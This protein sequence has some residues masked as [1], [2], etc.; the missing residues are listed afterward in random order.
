MITDVLTAANIPTEYDDG[1]G[2]IRQGM[3]FEWPAHILW[4]LRVPWP[5][6]GR[7]SSNAIERYVQA[8]PVSMAPEAPADR[9][10]PGRK[11]YRQIG[12][13]STG[14]PRSTAHRTVRGRGSARTSSTA[15]TQGLDRPVHP[16]RPRPEGPPT[17]PPRGR[18]PPGHV[19]GPVRVEVWGHKVLPHHGRRGRR[20]AMQAM[21]ATTGRC[22]L[23]LPARPHL[24]FPLRVAN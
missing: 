21:L 8:A 2:R 9:A 1:N 6:L 22:S 19:E 13:T 12:P 16:P 7:W 24:G 15:P 14:H 3:R 10:R 23:S 11:R 20:Q 4:P 17:G 5:V 18:P